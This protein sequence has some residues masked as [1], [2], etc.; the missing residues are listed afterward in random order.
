MLHISYIILFFYCLAIVLIFFY[1]LSQ[2]NLLFNYLKSK[3]DTHSNHTYTFEKGDSF[4]KVTVQL[5]LYNE[6]YV[7]ERLL[8]TIA[9]LDYP[10]EQLEIQVLDDSTDESVAF[11]KK[12]VD[13]LAQT[14]LDIIHLHRS[15]R[16]GFKA[17]ALKDGLAIAKGEF[18]AIF[19]ADFVPQKNWLL[20]TVPYFKDSKIGVVQTRWGHLNRNYSILTKIQAFALDAHFSLEQVGRN[21]QSH[22]INFNGT[23]G[24][25]R[26]SCILDAGNWQSDTL[27][28][29]LDLSY[30]AQLKNWKFK[31]LENVETPAELPAVIS[32]ARSQQFRWNKG[33]AENFSKNAK[34][35]LKSNSISIKTKVH[36]ILHLL[37]SSMFMA[38][39]TMS[40]LSIP[41]LFIKKK[42]PQ[43]DILFDFLIFFIITSLLFFICYWVTYKSIHGGGFRNFLDYLLMFITFYTIAMGFSFHNSVA[44]LEGLWGKK[45]EFVRTPKLNIEGRKDHWKQNSYLNSTVS[46]KIYFEGFLMLYFCF[47]IYSAVQLGD[48]SLVFFHLMLMLGYGYVFFQSIVIPK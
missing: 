11:T 17:G 44:V 20:Q 18:I 25:W 14:G 7:V 46:K 19:D 12:I 1:G 13:E 38:V 32:A 24:I 33:G 45:S 8:R 41:V 16:T 26:K 31:Y 30:R 35:V 37:N 43:F 22:F 47:G 27:T 9:T 39:F 23:A 4:P 36:G 21:S 40:V 48:F 29:D 6:K 2:F 3:K 28:E 42:F 15:H 5:P 34:R 10:R